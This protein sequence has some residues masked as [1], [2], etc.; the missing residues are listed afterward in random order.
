M[1]IQAFICHAEKFNLR[2]YLNLTSK[3]SGYFIF[4]I[5]CCSDDHVL[6]IV[7]DGNDF[8]SNWEEREKKSLGYAVDT[9]SL[10]EALPQ[11][12]TNWSQ[13]K[14]RFLEIENLGYNFWKM[15]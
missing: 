10:G 15:A 6:N 13:T 7:A 2:I 9:R 1:L 12:A 3:K 8:L 4:L 11:G 14:K 5:I